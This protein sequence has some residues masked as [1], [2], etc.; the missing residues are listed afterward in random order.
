MSA[1][2]MA[3]LFRDGWNDGRMAQLTGGAQDLSASEFLAVRPRATSE[4]TEAYLNGYGDGYREDT[5]RLFAARE[6]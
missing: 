4:E 5:F 1:A 2:W 6:G 3:R